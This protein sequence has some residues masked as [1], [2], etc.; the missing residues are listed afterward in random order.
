MKQKKFEIQDVLTVLTGV[1]FPDSDITELV[2][3]MKGGTPLSPEEA[4][5]YMSEV[6]NMI[7]PLMP[8]SV[9]AL[10]IPTLFTLE[11]KQLS[12]LVYAVKSRYG[13]T[14]VL[15]Y[16]EHAAN[17]AK[18]IMS[19]ATCSPSDT[20][21]ASFVAPAHKKDDLGAQLAKPSKSEERTLEFMEAILNFDST[22]K[23]HEASTQKEDKINS[24]VETATDNLPSNK[25]RNPIMGRFSPIM[26]GS[27]KKEET[28]EDRDYAKVKTCLDKIPTARTSTE[29]KLKS[30]RGLTQVFQISSFN[31]LPEGFV[32]QEEVSEG[33]ASYYI[34]EVSN[35]KLQGLALKCLQVEG[36]SDTYTAHGFSGGA[37]VGQFNLSPDEVKEIIS[38]VKKLCSFMIKEKDYQKA[39]ILSH[40][41]ESYTGLV[42]AN[43]LVKYNKLDQDLAKFYVA[44]DF[45]TESKIDYFVRRHKL[46]RNFVNMS[47]KITSNTMEEFKL[48]KLIY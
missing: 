41:V 35:G 28:A 48:P 5:F 18:R 39:F 34:A 29:F 32:Y 44:G 23:A 19:E 13:T 14:F 25:P 26:G 6:R 1:K 2:S 16:P 38:A 33:C 42:L 20:A 8:T 46:D 47:L 40:Y 10:S 9:L 30:F 24:S 17:E 15:Q 22:E 11:Q 21:M 12:N 27:S 36:S 3:F 4:Y 31:R 37:P 45:D 7:A 43:S